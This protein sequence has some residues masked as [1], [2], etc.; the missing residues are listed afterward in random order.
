MVKKGKIDEAINEL[1]E[2]DLIYHGT[3][4]QP[5]G[6]VIEDWEPREQMLFKSSLYGDEVDRP[7][8]KSNGEWTYFANDIAYHFDKYKRGS[9]H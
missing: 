1:K 2:Q 6:K 3:L 8:Q 5:K 9:D 4:E 7:L